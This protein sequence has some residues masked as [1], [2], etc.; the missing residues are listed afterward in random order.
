M[1]MES[2][3]KSMG[4]IGIIE[5]NPRA[6]VVGNPE[7]REFMNMSPSEGNPSPGK[8]SATYSIPGKK[9]PDNLIRIVVSIK[10]A[11]EILKGTG[12]NLDDYIKKAD[13]NEPLSDTSDDRQVCLS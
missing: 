5:F 7:R 10:T 9:T 13:A 12:I 11:N 2:T 8:P 6:T 1:E 3:L 4:A